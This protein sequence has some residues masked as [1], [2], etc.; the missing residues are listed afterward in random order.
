MVRSV[1][2]AASHGTNAAEPSQRW[3]L[4]LALF[5]LSGVSGLIYESIWS[6]YIRLFVGSAATA[7]IL[8]LGLFMGG[9]SG[10]AFLAGRYV[11]RI[12]TPILA[13][14][15]I[16]GVIGLYALA[17]PHL[18]A[19]ATA[20]CYEVL[21]PALGGGAAVAIAK[22]MVAGL[23]IGPPCIL[24]GTTF[25]LMS[26]GIL[27]RDPA[28]SGEVLSLLY[29]T[30]SLGAASGALLSGFVLVA[31]V[32]LPG[33]LMVAAAANLLIM[34]VAIGYRTPA[35][36]I[37]ERNPS[38]ASGAEMPVVG[39]FLAVALG[40]GLSSFMYE[41]AWI[42]L[43]S[44]ILGSATHSFEV[45]LSA[46]ILGLALGGL[47]V[48]RRMD[49]WKRPEVILGIIQLIMGLAAVATLPA[50]VL[51]VDAIH[52]LLHEVQVH[53]ETM[54]VQFNVL[55]Y[56]LCLLIMLPATFCAGM[57]LPLLTHVM[58][59]RGQSEK[60][61]GQ[62]YG[63]N[64]L[65]ALSGAVLAG[66]VLMPV[67]QL[68][69]VIVI[70]AV[71]DM[72]LGL[73]LL[74]SAIVDGT[75]AAGTGRLLRSAAV[76]TVLTVSFGLLFRLD[77]MVLASSVFRNGRKRLQDGYHVLS[78]VDGRTATVT[79]VR[80]EGLPSYHAIYTNGK[81]DASV[82][83]EHWPE[84]RDPSLGPQI[85]GDEPTQLLMGL[86]PL[87][88]RPEAKR[89]AVI[90]FGS[91][92]TAHT[93]LG[94]DTLEQLA[95]VEIEP[96]MVEG[97]R[98][99]YG[100][101]QRVYDD[102]RSEVHFDDAK[103]YF[104]TQREGFDIIASEP[105]NPWV[106][107]VASLFSVEFYRRTKRHLNEGG[108]LVQWIQGYEL[109]DALM[110]TVLAAL[111]REFDDYVVVRIGVRDWAIVASPHGPVGMMSPEVLSWPGMAESF[112]LLG[113]HDVG[114][115][116][117]LV[118]ATKQLLHPFVSQREPNRDVMP[119][120]D[121]GAEKARFMRKSAEFMHE[122][123]WTP[124]PILEV[125]GG[126]EA[127]PYPVGGIGDQRDAHILTEPEMAAYLLRVA[128]TGAARALGPFSPGSVGAWELNTDRL[129]GTE[130]HWDVWLTSTYAVYE[131]VAPHMPVHGTPWWRA[132]QAVAIERK[133]PAWV[134]DALA[135]L[136]ALSRRQGARL[137]RLADA[138]LRDAASPLP[139]S[140]RIVAGLIALEL[141]GA[142]QSQRVRFA[143]EFMQGWGRG[144]VN[145]HGV[146]EV[147]SQDY[148]LR[149]MAAYA[150]R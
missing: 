103:A 115:L 147:T 135:L 116:D 31:W 23:L 112:S 128:S 41:I 78:Y 101:N 96:E 149:V 59:R 92:V 89:V 25:P 62:V 7:Q 138:S 50:Y 69:G 68:K 91:G 39:I 46:F 139:R 87:M 66:L 144:A 142:E 93:I 22:W 65:G 113:V 15:L 125:L 129:A 121:V 95:T 35:P 123:R 19:F 30:N 137:W 111:D 131:Q 97:A 52:A 99:F 48:R 114:Q 85:A 57:T 43:L 40:T 98:A 6:R 44:M 67:V 136:D 36:P 54:W 8:V 75:A 34:V 134:R 32:G 141:I 17:F 33:T 110:M 56:A 108:L 145:A 14:A 132:V 102:P 28:R 64:T 10:G 49:R 16:E 106:S 94:S 150:R 81:P 82:Y 127:R 109:S 146:F 100:V 140:L 90:G 37:R 42:R 130:P 86:V 38:N 104:A 61:V 58:L 76:G 80:N 120:L 148:A 105:T 20:Q 27:R 133:A 73:Y 71:V 122:L 117:A 3:T 118:V 13:Y 77:P 11:S 74:R 51:A 4:L 55:R 21:F 124:A 107:G 119:L 26:V 12:R 88:Y 72:G 79:V 126:F 83:L 47:W 24:L 84:E 18:Y 1:P 53:T 2:D 5:L 60:V 70:A 29:F 63:L 9:M 45:M 143:D